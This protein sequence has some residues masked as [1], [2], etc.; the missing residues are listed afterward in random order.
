[1]SSADSGTGEQ[2]MAK[3]KIKSLAATW[4]RE[5]SREHVGNVPATRVLVDKRS[6]K[7]ERPKHVKRELEEYDG[8]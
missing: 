7:A 3:K 6:R 8:D 5:A 1:M 4:H 2:T